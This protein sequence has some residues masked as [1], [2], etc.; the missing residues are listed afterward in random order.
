V[1]TGHAKGARARVYVYMG[2]R[3]R[4]CVYSPVQIC[5][6]ALEGDGGESKMVEHGICHT[7]LHAMQHVLHLMAI[8]VAGW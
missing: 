3:V 2:V 4:E 7:S 5:I 1:Y 8:A 6:H